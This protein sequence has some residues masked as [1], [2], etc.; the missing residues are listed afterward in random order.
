MKT[1]IVIR[2]CD[3]QNNRGINRH[4]TR[5]GS[6]VKYR[7][8]KNAAPANVHLVP[9]KNPGGTS[10]TPI[11]IATQFT[12]HTKHKKA[13]SKRCRARTERGIDQPNEVAHP[14]YPVPPTLS[15]PPAR[16]SPACPAANPLSP[17][18]ARA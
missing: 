13:N 8:S 1:L 14:P 17:H 11:F 4:A 10:V 6:P 7:H 9:E 15:Q 18:R 3:N 5:T 16:P 2:I 12:P